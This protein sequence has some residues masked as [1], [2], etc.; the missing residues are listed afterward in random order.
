MCEE[1]QG[2]VDWVCVRK[3]KAVWTGCVLGRQSLCRLGVCEEDQSCV[4]WVY[5]RKPKA[6]QT[7][8]V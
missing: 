8:Y 2:C 1:D 6:V 7:G 5:V 3:I 4:D